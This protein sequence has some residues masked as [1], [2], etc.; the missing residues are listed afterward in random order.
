M[1]LQ[2]ISLFADEINYAHANYQFG[3]MSLVQVT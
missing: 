2:L 3:W 1:P